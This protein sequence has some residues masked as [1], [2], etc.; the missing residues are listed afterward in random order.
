V[1]EHIHFFD[2][3][4]APSAAGDRTS[5]NEK[6]ASSERLSCRERVNRDAVVAP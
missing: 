6:S 4:D 3:I 2:E 1:N 5:M